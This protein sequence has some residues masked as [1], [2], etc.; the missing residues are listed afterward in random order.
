MAE[1]DIMGEGGQKVAETS[2]QWL[3]HILRGNTRDYIS[4]FPLPI[5]MTQMLQACGP[6]QTS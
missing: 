6:A 1:H 3:C 5:T 4:S 2:M